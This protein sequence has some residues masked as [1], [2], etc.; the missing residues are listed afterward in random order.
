MKKDLFPETSKVKLFFLNIFLSCPRN[1]HVTLKTLNSPN[2]NSNSH[3]LAVF[4]PNPVLNI[5]TLTAPLYLTSIYVSTH[6]IHPCYLP[7]LSTHAIYPCYLPT[8]GARKADLKMQLQTLRLC[9]LCG[10]EL[11]H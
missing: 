6:A 11:R 5:H 9:Y 7:L 10:W 4:K 1:Y 2:S 8:G 3:S